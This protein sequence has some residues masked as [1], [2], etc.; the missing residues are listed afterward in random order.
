MPAKAL[1][2]RQGIFDFM[3]DKSLSE[4]A[5]ASLYISS[6][7]SR[8]TRAANGKD[9][10]GSHGEDRKAFHTFALRKPSDFTSHLSHW[11]AL[12]STQKESIED[13]AKRLVEKWPTVFLDFLIKTARAELQNR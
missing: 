9:K 3:A 12:T 4:A 6:P 11:D 13:G 8:V 2:F 10:G 7:G 1:E 5:R